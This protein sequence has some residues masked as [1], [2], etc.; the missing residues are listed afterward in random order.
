M[1]RR[2]VHIVSQRGTRPSNEVTMSTCI[3]GVYV[4]AKSL[5]ELIAIVSEN[6]N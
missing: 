2:N 3:N 4:H 6:A 5:A 1:R